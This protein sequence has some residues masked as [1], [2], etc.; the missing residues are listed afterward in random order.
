MPDPY[1]IG[2]QDSRQLVI[3][4]VNGQKI[5]YL[6]DVQQ[7]LK[8]PVNGFHI[9]QFMKGDTLQRIVLDAATLDAATKRVLDHYGIDKDHFFAVTGKSATAGKALGLN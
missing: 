1:N 4:K 7:A 5:N 8:K 6:A 9:F 3:E 2:Y